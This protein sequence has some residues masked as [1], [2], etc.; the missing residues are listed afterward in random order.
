M[1]EYI[2]REKVYNMLNALGGCD[3][4]P[5]TWA[6]GWDKAFDESIRE[7]DNIPAAD[8]RP[9]SHGYIVWK[10]RHGGGFREVKCLRHFNDI[11]LETNPP[12]KYIARYDARYVSKEPYCSECGNRMYGIYL[13]FC[14]N[15]GAMMDGKVG[16]SDG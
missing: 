12:C 5:D 8:V 4:E 6:D 1:A 3:A 11:R 15:C 16:E 10:E 13:N 7:L 2:E 9:E 14:D